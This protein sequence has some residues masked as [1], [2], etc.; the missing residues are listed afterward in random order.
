MCRGQVWK[1]STGKKG[2]GRKGT[3]KKRYGKMRHGK[4]RHGEK[5][6]FRVVRWLIVYPPL[7]GGKGGRTIE[8]KT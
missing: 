2:R 1:I 4:E 7:G 8:K 6:T 3:G 5:G